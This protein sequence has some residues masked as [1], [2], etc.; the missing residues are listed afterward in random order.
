M[1]SGRSFEAFRTHRLLPPT[2]RLISTI[3]RGV[4]IAKARIRHPASPYGIVFLRVSGVA[5]F[6]GA[7][8][9][10]SKWL[11]VTEI[12]NLK[13]LNLLNFLLFDSKI[14]DLLGAKMYF[15]FFSLEL[16][17]LPSTKSTARGG[18]S[19]AP[20]LPPRQPAP[21]TSLLPCQYHSTS[22]L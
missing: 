7:R 19:T 2:R 17:N 14:H 3:I 8:A 15:S 6:G 22:I 21:M 10:I 20:P 1:N 4:S 16:F 18:R 11:P 12:M 9:D 13:K 5:R